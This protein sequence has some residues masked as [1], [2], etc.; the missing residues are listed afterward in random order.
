MKSVAVA[1]NQRQASNFELWVK[2]ELSPSL[3]RI[4]SFA[5]SHR[6]DREKHHQQL[7]ST[8]NN[9]LDG[10]R[11]KACLDNVKLSLE[12]VD[13][14]LLD[15]TNQITA[16]IRTSPSF[17]YLATVSLHQNSRRRLSTRYKY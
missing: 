13:N 9:N 14:K 7:K 3:S 6:I 10:S 4:Q 16:Q 1:W 17:L 11:V 8:M 15:L 2:L 12:N 5:R